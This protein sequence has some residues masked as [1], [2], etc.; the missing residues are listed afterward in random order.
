MAVLDK[1]KQ[2]KNN[3]V[4]VKKLSEKLSVS[5]AT[6]KNWIKLNKIHPS[7]TINSRTY[8]TKEYC[9]TLIRQLNSAKS[10]LLK[11]RRNKKYVSGS[12]F[13]KDYLSDTSK[14]LQIISELLNYIS[15]KNIKLNKSQIKLIVANCAIQLLITNKKI[16][17]N[18][19]QSYLKEFLRKNISLGACNELVNDLIENPNNALHFCET[20]ADILK[21]NYIYEKNEDILGLLYISLSNLNSRKSSG[22]YYTSTKVIKKIIN[23]IN[24]QNFSDKN[25]IDPCCGAGNF[26]LQLPDTLNIE[27]I[28]GNDIDEIAINITRLNIAMK[29]KIKNIKILYKNFTAKNFLTENSDLKFDFIIGNPPWGA[30]FENDIIP[31]LKN[32]YLSAQCNNIES[33]DVFTE[34]SISCLKP[35]GNLFFVLPEA[36]LTVKNHQNI[37]KIILKNNSVKY[38]EYLGNMFDKVQCP[39]IIMQIQHTNSPFSFA[40]MKVKT[41][42]ENFVI[43]KERQIT[44]KVFNFSMSDEQYSVYKKILSGKGKVYLKNNAV[45]ALGIVTGNNKK[46]IT[47]KKTNSNEIILKGSDINKFK[48]NNPSNY[49][50][51]LPNDFQQVA[52]TEIYRTKEKLFYKFISKKLVFAYDNQQR[53]SLNSCNILIPKIKGV[54]IKYIM[55]IL[56]SRIAQ[57]IFEKKYNSVKVLR[58]HIEEI[59]IPLCSK[60]TQNEI[61]NIVDKILNDRGRQNDLYEILEEKIYKLYGL[62][63]GEYNIITA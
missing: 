7:K 29:F 33:Y 42:N 51:Y 5:E 46:H 1:H 45:F 25:I 35:D 17:T 31:E 15:E 8:F 56:N 38:V 37:R 21:N 18:I 47:G 52:R 54:N 39:A 43:K 48:I 27:Q 23:E 55:A 6:V 61:I 41:K 50:E 11:S 12:F 22:A 53:L 34:K 24:F 19:T 62:D 26:L 28:Y 2:I 13:Y 40:G 63:I 4:S 49:I 16:K 44:P 59:P 57:F 58:S 3:L 9:D 60:N 14:N 20:H 36:I 10:N 32:K 30:E